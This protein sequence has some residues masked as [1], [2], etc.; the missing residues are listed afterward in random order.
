ME[1]FQYLAP[2]KIIFGRGTEA[3]VGE[4]CKE[5]GAKKCLSTTAGTAL[6]KR[7]AG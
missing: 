6:K 3:R 5:Q 7:P 4:L 2:T 1:F